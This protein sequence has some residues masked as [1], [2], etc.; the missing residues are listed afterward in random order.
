M[1]SESGS[2]TDQSLGTFSAILPDML[3]VAT[4]AVATEA[5]GA[6][7]VGFGDRRNLGGD[8]AVIGNNRNSIAISSSSYPVI[9]SPVNVPEI[10]QLPRLPDTLACR[11]F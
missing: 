2:L 9:S 1:K 6:G 11:K 5:T 8:E 3:T 7:V 10:S 4:V